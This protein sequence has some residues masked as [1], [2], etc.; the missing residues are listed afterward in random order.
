ML[1]TARG[2][3]LEHQTNSIYR[4]ICFTAVRPPAC[5]DRNSAI[6]LSYPFS[7]ALASRNPCVAADNAKGVVSRSSI[8]Q[9]VEGTG[10]RG[11]RV[12]GDQATIN[13][14]V[15]NHRTRSKLP[16]WTSCNRAS[17]S[18]RSPRTLVSA[19]FRSLSSRA[20]R[21][22]SIFWRKEL[23]RCSLCRQ[24]IGKAKGLM[25]APGVITPSIAEHR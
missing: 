16:G 21:A 5:L 13:C 17:K 9:N 4:R 11:N 24:C 22:F 6:C 3:F 10:T 12:Y 25:G 14:L 19:A 15:T 1:Q 7:M 23:M 18:V 2:V 20:M 8:I